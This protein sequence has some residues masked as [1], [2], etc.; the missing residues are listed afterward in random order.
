MV[1]AAGIPIAICD[2]QHAEPLNKSLQAESSA[3]LALKRGT[4]S[5]SEPQLHYEID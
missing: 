2:P 5:A 3:L 1:K 4:S